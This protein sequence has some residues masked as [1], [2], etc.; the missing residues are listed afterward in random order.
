MVGDNSADEKLEDSLEEEVITTSLSSDVN[1]DEVKSKLSAE[2]TFEI[3]DYSQQESIEH[4]DD[5][6]LAGDVLQTEEL[7]KIEVVDDDS[8]L[9]S[10]D[11]ELRNLPK[12]SLDALFDPRLDLSHYKAPSLA[13]LDDYK[14][15]IYKVPHD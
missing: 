14:D 8:Q 10:E 4:N 1:M 15:S 11:V 9:D 13:L 6:N 5:A 12:E 7:P 2:P 3:I